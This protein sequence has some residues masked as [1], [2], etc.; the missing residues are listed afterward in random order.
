MKKLRYCALSQSS[1]VSRWQI[2]LYKRPEVE[3][4]AFLRPDRECI[5]AARKHVRRHARL[6]VGKHAFLII[7]WLRGIEDFD[8]RMRLVKVLQEQLFAQAAAILEG[9]LDFTTAAHRN[10]SW[11]WRAASDGCNR[12]H[13][14]GQPEKATP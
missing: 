5:A 7:V 4:V 11:R 9:K 2:R 14:A 6:H 3:Q 1:I 12:R 10:S 8:I 13:T